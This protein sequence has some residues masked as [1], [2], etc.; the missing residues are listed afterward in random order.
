MVRPNEMIKEIQ[1]WPHPTTLSRLKECLDFNDP[2][3]ISM[4]LSLGGAELLLEVFLIHIDALHQDFGD[5]QSGILA[6]LECLQ[7]LL[8]GASGLQKALLPS[9]E[10]VCL[11]CA[12]ISF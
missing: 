2:S 3:W 9:M 12:F 5:A 8:H 1:D 11:T 4:F 10:N 7:S 6:T